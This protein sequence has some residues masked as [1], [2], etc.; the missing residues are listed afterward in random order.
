MRKILP[1]RGLCFC[2]P[3]PFLEDESAE[4]ALNPPKSRNKT[5]KRLL[6]ILPP[7]PQGSK[8]GDA[9]FERELGLKKRVPA[10]LGDS[11]EG[12]RKRREPTLDSHLSCLPA[13]CLRKID[14]KPCWWD[15]QSCPLFQ[16]ESHCPAFHFCAPLSFLHPHLP[17]YKAAARS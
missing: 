11:C 5:T 2:S 3:W 10:S 6:I 13:S 1:S 14:I 12:L 4:R 8:S 9:F 7:P 15:V 16:L 17:L